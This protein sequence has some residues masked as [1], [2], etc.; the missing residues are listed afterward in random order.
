MELTIFNAITRYVTLFIVS[1]AS[2]FNSIN[3]ETS[4]IS[5]NNSD[6]EKNLDVINKIIDY[7]TITR[8]S[9]NVPTGVTH[10]LTEGQEGIIYLD[11]DGNTLKTLQEKIDKVVEVGI[12]KYGKY[13]GVITGY[14]PDC[15]TCDGRGYV[16]C[17]TN[18]GKYVNLKDDGIY[19]EDSK[20]GTVRILA[21]DHREFPCGTIIEIKNSDLDD[22]IIGVVLDTGWAMK[23][24]YN[25]GYI[26]IDLAFATEKKLK[27]N[28]NNNTSF[29]VQRWGW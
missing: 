1:L 8:Y 28:T 13:T 27:F 14:G 22:P 19:Y 11:E 21:A 17:P 26:H 10:V 9:Y 4:L 16:A 5:V 6:K 20:F 2:I 29:S 12:G 18:T 24:A 3:L 15:Y 23:N 7:E 25:N